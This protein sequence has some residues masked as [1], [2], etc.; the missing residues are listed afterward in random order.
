MTA[1]LFTALVPPP[2]VVAALDAFLEPRRD[3]DP[4]LRWTAPES[5]HVTTAFMA[6]VADPDALLEPLAA[7]AA[8][9]PALD[10]TFGGAG[11]MPTPYAARLLYLAAAP[12]DDLGRLAA[13]CRGALA[14]A[15]A[16]VD[17][18][19]FVPHLSVAR[20]RRPIEATRWLRVLDAFGPVSWRAAELLLIE[21]HV[22]DRGARY[23]VLERFALAGGPTPRD[24]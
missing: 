19:R 10:V 14:H 23:E 9:T 22:H 12:A 4:A 6:A 18:A 20:L 5:W 7:L 3:A 2:E 17:G 11:A 15:G 1:R 24:R 13:S 21:S 8:R 16:Q